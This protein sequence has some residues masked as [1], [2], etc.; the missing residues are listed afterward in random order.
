MTK[1]MTSEPLLPKKETVM[2]LEGFAIFSKTLPSDLHEADLKQILHAIYPAKVATFQGQKILTVQLP[3]METACSI[4]Q[5][6]R[7]TPRL[8]PTKYDLYEDSLASN[9]QEKKKNCQKAPDPSVIVRLQGEDLLVVENPLPLASELTLTTFHHDTKSV[10]TGPKFSS[11][12]FKIACGTSGGLQSHISAL[13]GCFK[14]LR[15][16]LGSETVIS[17]FW[18]LFCGIQ[19]HP[20]TP[21]CECFHNSRTFQ[22]FYFGPRDCCNQIWHFTVAACSTIS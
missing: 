6:R 20:G 11:E 3:K 18:R 1:A 22:T 14:V 2:R 10:R 5:K 13:F 8:V 12:L 15:E 7:R 4:E 19:E 17:N 16:E 9:M 21:W